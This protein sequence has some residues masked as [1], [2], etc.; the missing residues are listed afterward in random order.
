LAYQIAEVHAWRGEKDQAFDWLER[1]YRQHDGGLTY[2]GYDR[3]LDS[4][5]SDPR[6]KA[7]MTKM[8]LPLN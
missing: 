7:L 6:F 8:K 2:L 3:F 4:L 5:R 1:A